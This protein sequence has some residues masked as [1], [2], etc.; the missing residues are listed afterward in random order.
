MLIL[1]QLYTVSSMFQTGSNVTVNDTVIYNRCSAHQIIK[2]GSC[3]FFINIPIFRHLKLEFVPANP[4]LKVTYHPLYSMNKFVT[5]K[6]K[7]PHDGGTS[8]SLY[9]VIG[10]H[11]TL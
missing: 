6:S 9:G 3:L 2:Y 7:S 8:V 1:V 11:V 10:Y 4:A 5:N